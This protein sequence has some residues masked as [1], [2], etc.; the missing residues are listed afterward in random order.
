[1][2]ANHNFKIQ[3]DLHND[4][5]L[6]KIVLITMTLILICDNQN[7]ITIIKYMKLWL[8]HSNVYEI[9]VSTIYNELFI[10]NYANHNDLFILNC[11]IFFTKR[12]ERLINTVTIYMKLWLAQCIKL[13]ILYF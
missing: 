12:Y 2:C 8:T 9:V 13:W 3:F 10:W 6:Y 1:M 11:A 7:N 4:F 5:D